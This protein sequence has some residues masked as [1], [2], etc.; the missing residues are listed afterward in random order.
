MGSS[1]EGGLCLGRLTQK[2]EAWDL[3]QSPSQVP[4][5]P[6]TG[7][8]YFLRGSVTKRC[9]E[10]GLWQPSLP[11][12]HPPRLLLFP[13]R[14]TQQGSLCHCS[15]AT[16]PE[17]GMTH[18]TGHIH[19]PGSLPPHKAVCKHFTVCLGCLQ[20]APGPGAH[21]LHHRPPPSFFSDWPLSSIRGSNPRF[22]PQPH[23]ILLCHLFLP[24]SHHSRQQ[25]LSA[26]D[27]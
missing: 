20:R 17:P 26:P 12:T 9:C 6:T 3:D 11:P 10:R 5:E 18:R 1:R 14:T 27:E 8:P 2:D 16:L 13:D 24:C 19:V 22:E 25:R 15:K 4:G 7:S 23:L 21:T